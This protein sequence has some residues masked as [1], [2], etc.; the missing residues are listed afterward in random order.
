MEGVYP[1]FTQNGA[2]GETFFYAFFR[3]PSSLHCPSCQD[4]NESGVICPV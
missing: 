1:T 3:L 4:R 2:I